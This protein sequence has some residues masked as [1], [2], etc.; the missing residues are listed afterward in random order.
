[1]F[2]VRVEDRISCASENRFLAKLFTP[3]R[4]VILGSTFCGSSMEQATAE[5]CERDALGNLP[6]LA[7]ELGVPRVAEMQELSEKAFTV[8]ENMNHR[9]SAAR[10]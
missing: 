6:E 1:M 9:P 3:Q 8:E 5:L 10:M 2:V 4:S 7:D